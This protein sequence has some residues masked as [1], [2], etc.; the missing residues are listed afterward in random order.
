MIVQLTIFIRVQWRHGRVL[1]HGLLLLL[2][3]PLLVQLLSERVSAS[4]ASST[5]TPTRSPLLPLPLLLALALLP[6]ATTT[7]SLPLV[8]A[9]LLLLRRILRMP[10]LVPGGL[11]LRPSLRTSI[12]LTSAPPHSTLR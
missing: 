11:L 12:G 9:L 10:P 1:T 3:L 4:T 8:L 7:S 5:A 6:T 2:L